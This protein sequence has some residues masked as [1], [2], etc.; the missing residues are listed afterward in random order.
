MA[1][2]FVVGFRDLTSQ[3]FRFVPKLLGPRLQRCAHSTQTDANHTAIRG[4]GAWA[5]TPVAGVC[6]HAVC[7]PSVLTLISARQGRGCPQNHGGDQDVPS[8][9][10]GPGRVPPGCAHS[11]AHSSDTPSPQ[12]GRRLL[13][14]SARRGGSGGTTTPSVP[15]GRARRGSVSQ[16]RTVNICISRS[17]LANG[18]RVRRRSA[19]GGRPGGSAAAAPCP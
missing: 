17:R 2:S 16:S 4:P 19:A 5:K 18:G 14:G 6:A 10:F 7:G 9:R 8:S 13:A 3:C 11:G 15:R 12:P 1:P